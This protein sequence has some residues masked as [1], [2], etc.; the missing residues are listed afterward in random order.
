[1]SSNGEGETKAKRPPVDNGIHPLHYPVLFYTDVRA[2]CEELYRRNGSVVQSGYAG[3]KIVNVFGAEYNQVVLQNRENIFSSDRGWSWVI[4]KVFPGAI[5]TMDGDEHRYQRRI[6]TQAFKKNAMVD[7]LALMGPD[8]QRGINWKTGNRFKVYPAIKKLT[9]DLAATVFMGIRLGSNARKINRAFIHTVDASIAP[10]RWAIPGTTM[11]RGVRGQRVLAQ[12][13]TAMI[14]EKRRLETPDFFSQFCHAETETGE[15]FTDSEIVNHMIFLM[16]AAHDTTTSTLT[17]IFYA[18]AKHP[19]WQEKLREE[20]FAI[21]KPFLEFDDLEKM[22]QTELVIR[23]AL[24]MYPPLPV[25]P[26]KAV[27]HTEI[28]GYRIRRG[29]LVGVAPIHTHYMK[30][31][32]SEPERFDPGRFAPGREEHKKHPFAWVPFGGGAHMCIGQ[33]FAFMQVKSVIHQVLRRYCWDIPSGYEMP[34]QLVP[35]ARP[36]DGLPVRLKRLQ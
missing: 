13:F 18:L 7:Y 25:M 26:R 19:E 11:W 31:Y 3:R 20:A 27:R 6:M 24:R 28:G 36:K 8:I 12:A 32:W 10:V 1:M 34:F 9:L 5:M 17:T 30:E 35:I 14:P 15:R 21:D 22:T 4:G 29:L 16:M 33:H 2:V 23:E